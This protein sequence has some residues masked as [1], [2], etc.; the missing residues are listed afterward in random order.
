MPFVATAN[1][2]ANQDWQTV[3]VVHSAPWIGVS[4]L[5]SPSFARQV[6]GVV[7]ATPANNGDGFLIQPQIYWALD[8]LVGFFFNTDPSWG[9][10]RPVFRALPFSNQTNLSFDVILYEL[11]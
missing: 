3:D 9:G 10:I 4:N 8:G 6:R 11:L 5:L 1:L 2:S 7:A